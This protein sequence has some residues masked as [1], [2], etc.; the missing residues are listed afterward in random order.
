M[1]LCQINDEAE[2]K[3]KNHNAGF[4]MLCILIVESSS[5]LN[6][7]AH[8]LGYERERCKAGKRV[9]VSSGSGEVVLRL[10]RKLKTSLQA[11]R[12]LVSWKVVRLGLT[13]PL[14]QAEVCRR[15]T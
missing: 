9:A 3:K 12:F 13:S 2:E 10:A 4:G 15:F 14:V 1:R 11:F 8:A 6:R 7:P 5:C